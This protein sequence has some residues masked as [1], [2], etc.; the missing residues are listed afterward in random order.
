MAY[1]HTTFAALK[2]QLA[3]RLADAS[4]VFWTDSEMG[5]AIKEALRFRGA[6]TCAWRERGTFNTTAGT[7]FYD[8]PTQ[9]PT[10]LAYTVT[11]RDLTQEIQD[12]L[13]EPRITSAN[14]WTWT[15]TDQF[16]LSDVVN[17]IQR[18]RNQFLVETGIV[19]TH[20]T[21]TGVNPPDGR[22]QLADT[23]ID[24]RRVAWQPASGP[25]A[26]LF[27]E[28]EW[29]MTSANPLW[30]V[31]PGT[32]GCFSVLAPPPLTLQIEPVP[33][34]AGT[35]D[36]VTIIS[37][38]DLDVSTGVILGI[39]DDWCWAVKWG[40]LADLLG[41][42]GPSRDAPRAAYCETR[43]QQAVQLAQE[44]AVVVASQINGV[45]LTDVSL[46][47]LDTAEPGWQGRARAMPTDIALVGPN[48]LALNPVPDGIYS[49]TLDVVRKCPVP[50]NDVDQIQIGREDM[51]MVLDYAEHICCFKMAGAEFE[52]TTRL[53]KNFTDQAALYNERLRA[54]ARDLSAEKG[55]SPRDQWRRPRKA[56]FDTGVGATANA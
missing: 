53:F 54:M 49:I 25:W 2:T 13:I 38:A 30:T 23:V 3:S 4:K 21:L 10:Q 34:D 5:N 43:Y 22:V 31:Q 20:S 39:P 8:L 14:G 28:D 12:A 15:G 11:D 45:P 52:A 27:R 6:V 36:V 47:E 32:P 17:A 16:I 51:E 1:A 26:T 50:V 40:A 33:L 19:A 7:A 24:V 44:I 48:L 55:Q 46:Q 18:R 9:L 42:D 37:G 41:R 29:A 56:V 35:L